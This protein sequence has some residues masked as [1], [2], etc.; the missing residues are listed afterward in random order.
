MKIWALVSKLSLTV[1]YQVWFSGWKQNSHGGKTCS[2]F[3]MELHLFLPFP[4]WLLSTHLCSLLT[5]SVPVKVP[6][7]YIMRLPSSLHK[8]WLRWAYCS[9]WTKTQE[10]GFCLKSQGRRNIWRCWQPVLMRNEATWRRSETRSGEKIGPAD[11]VWFAGSCHAWNWQDS[12]RLVANLSFFHVNWIEL[13]FI[14]L[15]T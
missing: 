8:N 12:L 5:H 15:F 4:S 9:T 6:M 2:P 10:K 14:S 3:L 13:S 1:F 7:L 11:N